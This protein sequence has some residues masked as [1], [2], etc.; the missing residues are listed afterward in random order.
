MGGPDDRMGVFAVRNYVPIALLCVWLLG[1]RAPD[2]VMDLDTHALEALAAAQ[3]VQV[4]Q[5]PRLE[6]VA[7]VDNAVHSPERNRYTSAALDAYVDRTMTQMSGQTLSVQHRCL[8]EA[9]YFEARGEP[10]KGQ[11]AVAQVILNRVASRNFPKTVCGVVYDV[12]PDANT[13]QFSFTCDAK[14]ESISDARAWRQAQ[15]VALIAASGTWRDVTGDATYFH[16]D[17]V[18][19]RWAAAFPRTKAVGSH[20]FY[21]ERS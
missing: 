20:I 11:L 5:A 16:A 18:S 1:A 3:S 8:S 2:S 6:L 19:P 4:P 7:L 9:V 17:Y 13:C 21:R 15:A 14:P 10:I 12:R